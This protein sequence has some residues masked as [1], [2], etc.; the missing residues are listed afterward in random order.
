ML[1]KVVVVVLLL[2]LIPCL[3]FASEGTTGKLSGRVFD[4]ASG[5]PLPGVNVIIEG[6]TLGAATDMN[7]NYFINNIPAG[8]YTI[9]ASY[10]GYEKIQVENLNIMPDYT[11]KR[12]F[13][14]VETQI[15]GEVVVVTAERPLIQQDVTNTVR[16]TTAEEMQ[17]L[18]TRGTD[19]VVQLQTGV[20][21]SDYG[22]TV[23]VRGGRTDE[24][25]YIVDG[26][27]VQSSYGGGSSFT[28]ND[29]AISQLQVSTGGFNAEYGRQM[30]GSVNV[31]TKSG[32]PQFHGHIQGITDAFATALN[33]NSYG[34][35]IYDFSI[36]GRLPM[37][38]NKATFF[39]SGEREY[40]AD[41]APRPLMDQLKDDPLK[42]YGPPTE[43]GYGDPLSLTNNADYYSDG[44]IPNHDLNSYKWHG[45]L[46]YRL[47]SAINIEA[48]AFG[49]QHNAASYWYR[50][51][52][53][54]T[55]SQWAFFRNNAAFLKV[56]HTL[57]PKTFYT[58]GVSHNFE[59][60]QNN[61][62][63]HGYSIVDYYRGVYNQ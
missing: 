44:R 45:K 35:N 46:N 22:N 49:R 62:A 55:A 38:N 61:Q 47:S 23:T 41:R 2:L 56:T 39:I 63:Q 8:T 24:I 26:F 29:A 27:E 13:P 54:L 16:I 51:R 60:N 14:M 40:R 36:S 34:Y 53:D 6:T 58:I 57:S 33:T 4:K 25:T 42:L 10:I 18:P 1:N 9:T 59:N 52:F 31:V 48:G 17:N 37:T 43:P 3:V 21:S 30:S 5:E 12:E 7:G 11:T 32:S 50:G 20:V 15:E 19:A 28:V